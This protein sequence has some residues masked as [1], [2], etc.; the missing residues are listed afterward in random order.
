ML[1]RPR[2]CVADDDTG[3]RLGEWQA[4]S[5]RRSAFAV[6]FPVKVIESW[7][8]ARGFK[9]R[10]FG[11]GRFLDP[12]HLSGAAPKQPIVFDRENDRLLPPLGNDDHRLLLG[13]R[14]PGI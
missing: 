12:D 14:L 13:A 7:G 10:H 11:V 6:E 3:I 9:L 8:H 4:L 5:T 1:V 2:E